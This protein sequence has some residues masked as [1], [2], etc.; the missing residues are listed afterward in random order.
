M[1][2]TTPRGGHGLDMTEGPPLPLILSFSLP[3]LIGNILQQLYN[4]VD[5]AVAG[6]FVGKAAL[7]AIPSCLCSPPPFPA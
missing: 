4:M 6:T 3:L 1:R 5:S 2:E 7:S